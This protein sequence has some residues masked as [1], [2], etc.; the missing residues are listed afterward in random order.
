MPR[1]QFL[2]PFKFL[3]RVSIIVLFIYYLLLSFSKLIVFIVLVIKDKNND[4]YFFVCF[5]YFVKDRN[6]KTSVISEKNNIK[7]LYS[8]KDCKICLMIQ[9][10]TFPEIQLD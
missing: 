4:K 3:R 10:C 7:Y 8:L 5:A 6:T 9:A 1:R 2:L